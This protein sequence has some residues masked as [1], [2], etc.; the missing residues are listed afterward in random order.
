MSIQIYEMCNIRKCSRICTG[1]NETAR[2]ITILQQLPDLE[3]LQQDALQ[4]R[5]LHILAEYSIRCTRYAMLH[6]VG[7]FMITVGSLIV[8]ALLSVQY[9]DSNVNI[10]ATPEL[11][12]QV[13]WITWSISLMVTMFNGLLILYKVDK[14]YYFLHTTRERLRSEG[15]QYVQLTGRY[16]GGLIQYKEK[17]THANQFMF[18]CHYVEK[19]RMRQIEEEYYKHEETNQP[20]SVQPDG[21][22]GK[23]SNTSIGNTELYGTSLTADVDK[24][25]NNMIKGGTPETVKSIMSTL[26]RSA[27]EQ[28]RRASIS[29]G[30][31]QPLPIATDQLRVDIKPRT[32]T[33]SVTP[34]KSPVITPKVN[35]ATAN[36]D[37]NNDTNN[38]TGMETPKN[39]VIEPSQFPD[40]K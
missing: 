7:H 22:D 38:D 31:V 28:G 30:N 8:P 10:Y 40:S 12:A 24:I 3:K 26:I 15:W 29:K 9:A 13:Y 11:R 20:T 2:L 37:M 27:H 18:F 35:T 16:A 23:T 34:P 39:S 17:S 25:Y 6:H 33:P 1:Q 32:Q 21:K 19:I 14:K 4:Y 5:Y 36:S